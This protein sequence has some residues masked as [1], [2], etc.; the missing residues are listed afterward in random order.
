MVFSKIEIWVFC[1]QYVSLTFRYQLTVHWGDVSVFCMWGL[2]YSCVIFVMLGK[3]WNWSNFQLAGLR[4]IQRAR[5]IFKQTWGSIISITV[6]NIVEIMD[7]RLSIPCM[8][9]CEGVCRKSTNVWSNKPLWGASKNT[10]FRTIFEEV[11]FK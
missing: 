9:T 10:L 1:Y 4:E 2:F 6:E 5:F 3:P 11:H 8:K 7:K